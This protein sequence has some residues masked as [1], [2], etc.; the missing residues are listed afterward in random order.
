MR[1]IAF[2]I[3]QM[4]ACSGILYGYYHLFLR[5]KNF[6]QY[7]RYYLLAGSVL[8]LLIPF[9]KIPVYLT[10]SNSNI[11]TQALVKYNYYTMPEVVVTS[12]AKSNLLSWQAF[13]A[14][15]YSAIA[16]LLL[17]RIVLAIGK[18]VRLR[19]VNHS[20]KWGS[21][22]FIHT[23]EKE[24]PFSFFNWIFWNNHIEIHSAQ[25]AKILQHEMYHARQKHSFDILFM[26]I[27]C[28]ILWFNP[29]YHLFKKELKALHEFL[30]DNHA[31]GNCE[32]LEYAEILV[33]QAIDACKHRLVNPFF[34]SQLKRRI[35][36]LTTHKQSKYH[37]ALKLMALPLAVL[38][39][40]LFV[41]SCKSKDETKP[42]TIKDTVAV[43]PAASAEPAKNDS[44]KII[45]DAEVYTDANGKTIPGPEI[46]SKV[47]I[48][49]AFP[50]GHTAW[51]KFL[52]TNLRGEVPVDNGAGPGTYTTVAQ[53]I[54]DK[55]GIVSDVKTVQKAGYGMDE[56]AIRVIKR[57]GRWKPAIQNG[58]VV[59]SYRKQPVTFQ[60]VEQ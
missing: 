42:A 39:A 58:K 3:L 44:A 60:V 8:S 17:L 19:M 45:N 37:Y 27:V 31:A 25:G 1:T 21:R 7:N 35:T 15:L 53:F 50:G 57:S 51:R 49:A 56:E 5:N 26:E 55:E 22:L 18:L 11:V 9:I 24:A 29:F 4:I 30:A 14:M 41:V 12:S 43:A 10:A 36:M 54:V 16:F 28:A 46:F 40:G 20:E 47:E 34:N 33:L 23:T 48:D 38:I 59:K 32:K 2:P 6:H 13:A 52:Q